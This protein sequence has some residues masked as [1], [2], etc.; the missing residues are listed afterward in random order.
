[1]IDLHVHS[2]GNPAP[3]DSPDEEPGTEQVLRVVLRAGVMGV[4]DMIGDSRPRLALRDRLRDS[5]EHAALFVGAMAAG[6]AGRASEPAL[7]ARVR[8][9]HA[10]GADVIKTFAGGGGLEAVLAEAARVR[11]PS[12]VHISSWDEARAGGARG[13]QRHHPLRGRGGD[14]GGPGAADG[15][16]GHADHPHHGGA[17]RSG[18]A[19]GDARPAGQTRC[20]ARV[21]GP[22]LRAAY[23]DPRRFID[24]A[25]GWLEWQRDGC[26][27]HDYLSVRRLHAASVPIL[28]GSDTGNLG[29][30]QGFS[31]H[32]ELELLAEAGLPPWD[33]LRAGTTLAAR[34]LRRALGR[35]GGSAGNLLVLDASP[36][37]RMSNTRRIRHVVYR[38]RLLPGQVQKLNRQGAEDAK[39]RN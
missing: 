16:A 12:V 3:D 11:L 20:S 7:R 29:T 37:E 25:R 23:R 10:A 13:G 27:P 18:A 26:V 17:V 8:Q 34:F 19:G 32:R 39:Y 6:W 31:L 2:W 36:L 21:T 33:A 30:F 22:S 1:M 24:K 35:A 28:A 14:P 9:L 15:G 38:G 5:P 4:L